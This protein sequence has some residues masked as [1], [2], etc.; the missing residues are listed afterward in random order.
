MSRNMKLYVC[1]N[2]IDIIYQPL[3]SVYFCGM[4]LWFHFGAANDPKG[5]NGI[6]HFIE[7]LMCSAIHKID[8]YLS[9]NMSASTSKDRI[10]I[11]G[12]IGTRH[13]DDV[14]ERVLKALLALNIDDFYYD[15]QKQKV[16]YEILYLN[17]API[18][19][20]IETF[21]STV[22]KVNG[23]EQSTF[24][25]QDDIENI[26][27]STIKEYFTNNLHCGLTISLVGN[28]DIKR[29]IRHLET[30]I[31]TRCESP[32]SQLFT[33]EHKDYFRAGN[34]NGI[35]LIYDASKICRHHIT[36]IND[37]LTFALN[38]LPILIKS[39]DY[40]NYQTICVYI[41]DNI[42]YFNQFV[43]KISDIDINTY[44]SIIREY[45][46]DCLF[47]TKN[48]VDKYARF[49]IDNYYYKEKDSVEKRIARI[50]KLTPNQFH[51]LIKIFF[52]KSPVR[53]MS[54]KNQQLC[55]L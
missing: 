17:K 2:N 51:E 11:G 54:E 18:L 49:N 45:Q 16:I 15:F 39:I 14:F 5:M 8:P 6:A 47:K 35:M 21:E 13:A 28:F 43:H 29:I 55:N 4:E 25:L 12:T 40:K 27:Y 41:P 34:H 33:L 7:H 50:E 37:Y 9:L 30:T 19:E 44:F 26:K 23:Y 3:D 22:M 10:R 48:S 38:D 1:K 42:S 24:G 20:Y 36:I 31:S 32:N 52:L 46:I 53:I